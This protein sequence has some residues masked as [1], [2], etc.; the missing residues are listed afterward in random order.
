MRDEA[1][2]RETNLI[3]QALRAFVSPELHSLPSAVAECPDWAAVEQMATSHSVM[4]VV[5]YSVL[6]HGG[7]AIPSAVQQRLR[8][9]LLLA[10]HNNL[11]LIGEWCRL[12]EAFGNAK[13]PV[14]SLK[15]PAV[16]LLVYPNF[17]LR[18]FTDLDLMVRPEDFARARDLLADNGYLADSP[19]VTQADLT[20]SRCR[21]S[22]LDFV[23]TERNIRVDLHW[24]AWH[25]MFPFQLPVD[26]LF[27]SVR[28]EHYENIRF[29]A[30]SPETLLLYLCAHGTKHC[31]LSLRWLCD[32]AC[33]LQR[34][35]GLNWESCLHLAESSNCALVLKHS[36]L[37]AH[38]IFGVDLPSA[39]M[40]YCNSQRA[41]ALARTASD[42][43]LRQ[44]SHISRR[45]ALSF[46][47]AF[48]EGWRN[49]TRLIFERLFIPDE[50]GPEQ[51]LPVPLR[52]LG[53][54]IKPMRLASRRFAA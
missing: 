25:A 30:L 5:A 43:L 51:H 8:Q 23:H 4:P 26:L 16:A 44:D 35:R 34:S 33:H 15:G 38:Q 24:G 45:Q 14:I 10:S 42:L 17:A 48:A 52:F 46:H 12:L 47:L 28:R 3:L 20:L 2:H 41:Q 9:R 39:V 36:L 18:E 22:Q 53:Y 54:A 13:I 11:T 21:N 32:V 6:Q 7:D 37:L 1:T 19:F 31:W 29:L 27:E 50:P 40:N 49:R